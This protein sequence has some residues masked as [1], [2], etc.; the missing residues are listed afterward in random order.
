MPRTTR[1]STRT[2]SA[3]AVARPR[4]E[5]TEMTGS[6][7]P[8]VEEAIVD[9]ILQHR[10]TIVFSNSRRLAER[11][12][13]R[14]NEI[15]SE[16]L[17]LALP[18]AAIPAAMMAQAGHQRGRRSGARESPPRVGV[19]GAAGPGRG[20]AQVRCPALRRR[21]QQPRARHRHG[22][23]RP[24]DPG[25][26]AAERGLRAPAHRPRRAPGRRGQ[27]RRA[28]PQAPRRRPA[29]RDRHRADAGRADRGDLRAPEPARHPRAADGRGIRP[30]P[31][32]RRG[33]VRDGQA[34]RPV[35]HASPL[36]VRGDARPARGSIPLGRVRRAASAARLGPRPRH[37]HGSAR[38]AADRR[39]QRRHDPRPR[40]VRR[41]RRR[42]VAERAGRRARR[43]DGLRV[44][45][46]RRLHARHDQLADRRD[47][48][49]PRQRPAG[50]RAAGQAAVLARRRPRP[51]RRARRGARQVLARGVDRDPREGPRRACATRV[52]TRTRPANLLAYLARAAR[53]HRDA[54][55]R[56]HAHGGT[57][58]R[59]GRR[60]ARHPSFPL[61]HESARAVGAGRQRP[62]PRAARAS[63]DRRSRATT[64]SSRGFRM[65]RPSRR[66]PSCSSSTP[67]SSSR[68]S[69]TRSADRRC[70]PRGS[71]SARRARC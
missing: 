15:Y 48:P 37:A 24:R 19:E 50:V 53:G 34:Q 32:R 26:G 45:G 5:S 67:T 44:A 68:S 52:S 25:R 20:G 9:R 10:S 47:H 55:D 46:Q 54:A 41:L 38:R 43:G 8:H 61:R 18:D 21:H 6:L 35:P 22:R 27:P 13:G 4:P 33:L 30:R 57:R 1:R 16:R 31:G 56:P 7:W 36:G 14:L 58:P 66:A 64:A 70:S 69:P 59:R 40:T 12:T 63:K 60:L 62:H 65:P 2:G 3:T 42:R 28:V 49:R 23:R 51:T 39:H 71:A 29:H 11:L 17:G